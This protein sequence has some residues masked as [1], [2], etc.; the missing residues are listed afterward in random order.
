MRPDEPALIQTLTEAAR[1]WLRERTDEYGLPSDQNAAAMM[2]VEAVLRDHNGARMM[3]GEAPLEQPLR[4]RLSRE[5]A[6]NLAGT[7]GLARLLDDEAVEDIWCNG[8]DN[9]WVRRG[10]VD[11]PAPPVASSDRELIEM[12]RS[13]AAGGGLAAQ[14]RRWDRSA[15]ILDLQL[16]DGSRLNAVMAVSRRPAVSIRR[17][18]H[19]KADLSELEHLGVL[20]PAMTRL[21]KAAVAGRCNIVVSGETGVGKT[22]L[23]RALAALLD[24]AERLITIEDSY[25]LA[26]DADPDVHANV[27]ALQAR[28]ANL[29]GAGEVGLGDLFRAG[30][31]M[32]PSRVFVGEV[33]GAET[34]TMLHAMTQGNDGSLSTIHASS[35]EGA[36][37]KLMLYAL[38]A[39][40]QLTETAVARLIA[41]AVDLVVHLSRG[42]DRVRRV[43]S[44]R[45]LCSAHGSTVTSNELFRA[46]PDGGPVAPASPPSERLRIRL[47]AAGWRPEQTV[48]PR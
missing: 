9:V 6:A 3:N 43:V 8:C 48:V 26:L 44:I 4:S 16:P 34:I 21:L 46:G 15:P 38:E 1:E 14:E 37:S 40:S 33:R 19:L 31:R 13:I 12:V 18:R 25:E 28:S 42:P 45:E 41:E 32:N 27:V 17:H 47:A 11:Q 39:A 7:G 36:V 20:T 30:L 35:S 23:L 2:A 22:T 10:G 5:V 29:E 24:P